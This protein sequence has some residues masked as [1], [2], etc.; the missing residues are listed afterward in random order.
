MKILQ[1]SIAALAVL[2]VVLSVCAVVN[3]QVGGPATVAETKENHVTL[4]GPTQPRPV[5]Y[6]GNVVRTSQV[7]GEQVKTVSDLLKTTA[8]PSSRTAHFNSILNDPQFKLAGW[9]LDI[10][11][12]RTTNG[13]ITAKVRAT[14]LVV[15]QQS[16]TVLGAIDEIYELS[17]ETLKLIKT[18]A[19]SP[20][21]GVLLD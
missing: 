8:V 13:T 14:P 11:E 9:S 15:G 6:L 21:V 10:L 18:E 3:S 2:G 20:W 7:G 1:L 5:E 19:P 4:P 17:G 16:V 12:V